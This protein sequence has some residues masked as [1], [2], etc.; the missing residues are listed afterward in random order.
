MKKGLWSHLVEIENKNPKKHDKLE[1]EN[2]FSK[3]NPLISWQT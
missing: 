2:Q 1:S 3:N